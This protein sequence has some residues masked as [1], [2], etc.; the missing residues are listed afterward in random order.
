MF[1]RNTAILAQIRAFGDFS[2]A[3]RAIIPVIKRFDGKVYNKRLENAL[4]ELDIL[5][6]DFYFTVSNNGYKFEIEGRTRDRSYKNDPDGSG[7]CS[8]GYIKHDCFT[9][10]LES[11]NALDN[12]RIKADNIIEKLEETAEYYEDKE[13]KLEKGLKQAHIMRLE[14]QNIADRLIEFRNKYDSSARDLLGL[15]YRLDY[16]GTSEYKDYNIKTW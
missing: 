13:F 10:I 7:Y 8:T 14:F 12:G 11:D 5:G 3:A 15:D 2:K 16:V 1:N 4:N 6:C 9:A